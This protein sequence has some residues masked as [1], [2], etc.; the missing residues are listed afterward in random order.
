[1]G[2]FILDVVDLVMVDRIRRLF[3]GLHDHVKNNNVPNPFYSLLCTDFYKHDVAIL[4]KLSR[5]HLGL[6]LNVYV[7][8]NL[9]A[10]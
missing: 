1:M 3:E 7:P 10:V 6:G 9:C 4:N 8:G 5:G 2:K